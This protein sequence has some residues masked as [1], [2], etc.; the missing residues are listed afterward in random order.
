MSTAI[1]G[2]PFDTRGGEPSVQPFRRWPIQSGPVRV[3][4]P[5][6]GNALLGDSLKIGQRALL[7]GLLVLLAWPASECA[8]VESPARPLQEASSVSAFSEAYFDYRGLAPFAAEQVEAPARALT[9]D[10][11]SE[12]AQERLIRA[13]QLSPGLPLVHFSLAGELARMGEFQRAWDAFVRGAVSLPGHVE[14]RL[15]WMGSVGVLLALMMIVSALGFIFLV[16]LMFFRNAA[17]DLGDLF[18]TQMPVFARVALLSA[19]LLVPL[20]LGEGL[21]GLSCGFFVIGVLYGR[22]VHRTTL[23]LAIALW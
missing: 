2:P 22:S 6:E 8:A 21:I 15:W 5:T 13:A 19:C 7:V 11:S 16:G 9:L 12:G 4:S 14:G 20:A 3:C 17:H 18:S 1:H 23:A 10:T